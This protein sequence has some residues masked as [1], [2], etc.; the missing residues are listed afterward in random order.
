MSTKKPAP[1]EPKAIVE[2]TVVDGV[3]LGRHPLESNKPNHPFAQFKGD[4][5]K[6]GTVIQFAL[7]NGVTYRGTVSEAVAED[8]EVIA[9]FKDGLEIVPAK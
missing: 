9:E 7:E 8:S 3:E 1:A 4:A 2:P 5:P 6:A